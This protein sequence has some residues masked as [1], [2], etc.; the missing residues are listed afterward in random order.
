MTSTLFHVF[1]WGH[2]CAGAIG[3]V[4]FWIPIATRKGGSDH[5]R[6]GRVFARCML[7]TGAF[8]IGISTCTLIDPVET[9]P[10]LE[11]APWVRGIF[12]WMMLYLAVLTVNL[13]WY[14]LLCIRNRRDHDANAAW[15][16]VGLQYLLLLLALNTALQGF[17][18]DQ[19]L[20][21]GMS[22]VGVAA[23]LTNLRF[24]HRPPGRFGWQLEHVKGL[25]GAGISVYTAFLAFGAVRLLPSA[26]LSPVLWAIPLIGGIA[27]IL[28]FWR[29]IALN[30]ARQI[31][32]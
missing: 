4:T 31:A 28:W 18:I 16:N 22:I 10:H 5:V 2:I 13:A 27:M 20:M 19:F 15:H 9:H 6:G 12:G 30:S 8:A 11:D 21:V 23:S 26:A 1:L 7:I 25:V 17:L 14:G 32:A 24:I 3:L 29:R